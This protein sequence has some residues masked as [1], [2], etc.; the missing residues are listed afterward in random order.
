MCKSNNLFIFNGRIGGNLTGSFTC[1]DT[2]VV[3]YFIG[4]IDIVK[5]VT[6]MKILEYS[7]LYSDVH[8]PLSLVLNIEN[9][10]LLNINN[11]SDNSN[12]YITKIKHWDKNKE[13]IYIDS[14]DRS[15]VDEL[16]TKLENIEENATEQNINDITNM[17]NNTY[18][19]AAKETFGEI[20]INKNNTTKK[21]KSSKPWFLKNVNRQENYTVNVRE[22]ILLQKQKTQKQNLNTPRK[23]I[24]KL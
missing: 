20:K 8:K 24:R 6:E 9:P 1:K 22:Y 15:A 19:K 14:I 10:I 21:K 7:T 3:D 16:I 12:D 18:I 23:T 17:L 4:S 5:H 11:D 13:H 2:S